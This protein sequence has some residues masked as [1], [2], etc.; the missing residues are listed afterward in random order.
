MRHMQALSCRETAKKVLDS[1]NMT[2]DLKQIHVVVRWNAY[3]ANRHG[4]E[5]PY[6]G[7]TIGQPCVNE[8]RL[9]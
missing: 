5:S 6:P 7:S 9:S 4:S 8:Q 2:V 3:R 1:T